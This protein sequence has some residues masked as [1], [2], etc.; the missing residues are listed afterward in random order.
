LLDW[1]DGA[2]LGLYFALCHCA[3]IVWMLDAAKLNELSLH[4]EQ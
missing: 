3:P 4:P 2:L 1:T